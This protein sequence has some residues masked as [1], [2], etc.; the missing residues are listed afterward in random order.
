M[1]LPTAT[2]EDLYCHPP[3]RLPNAKQIEKSNIEVDLLARKY[4]GPI[5][6]DADTRLVARA[7]NPNHDNLTG[8]GNPPVSSHW[9]G[10]MKAVYNVTKPNRR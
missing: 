10:A 1:L 9:S 7:H 4:A 6:I 2:R 8:K 5:R 3:L